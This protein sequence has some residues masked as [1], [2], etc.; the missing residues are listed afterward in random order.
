MMES[1]NA[2]GA[3]SLTASCPEC[4]IAYYRRLAGSGCL[5]R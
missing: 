1:M 2:V 5:S 3:A 4:P